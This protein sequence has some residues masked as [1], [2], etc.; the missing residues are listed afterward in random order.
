MIPSKCV[1]V[2]SKHKDEVWQVKFSPSGAKLA[3]VGKDNIL[4]LWTINKVI[5]TNQKSTSK[6]IKYRVKCTH[7]IRG[8]NK[9]VNALNWSV[10]VEDKWLVTAS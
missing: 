5:A 2:L 1:G 9:Q 7:E 8:H 6:G 4:Y 10:G 3:T